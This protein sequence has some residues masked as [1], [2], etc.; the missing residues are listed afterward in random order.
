MATVNYRVKSPQA[1]TINGVAAGGAM[2]ARILTGYDNIIR[3]SPD[4]LE[5][6][7]RDKEI[8]FCRGTVV[9]QDY[10]EAINLL[11]G[12]SD[13]Y[14][15]YERKSGVAA[16]TGYI[17]HTITNPVIH[18]ITIR[19]TKGGY[20]VVEFDFE[21]KAAD[22]TKGITDMWALEDDQAAPTYVSAARGGYR[23]VSTTHG[24]EAIYH[25][26]A[27]DFT[28]TLRL[29]RACNDGDV[30]YTCVDAYADGGLTAGGSVSFQDG[31]IDTAVIRAQALAT[32][33]KGDLVLT[34]GQAQGA[35]NKII[36]IA[37]ADFDSVSNNSDANSPFTVYTGNFEVS[38]DSGTQLT[39]EGANKIL[40]IE[41]A[42]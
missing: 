25:V 14:V 38:N 1:I 8:E 24:G 39:L 22:E 23:V 13:T 35:A 15:F 18:R 30:G 26:T 32:A 4:G 7:L 10:S 5:V 6:P 19:Q 40:T 12:T 31:S 42:A 27:F 2:T 37:N 33:D 9:C 28:I 29:A 21:C 41:D 36:T 11:T 17:K 16:T 34:L 20:A 3:S